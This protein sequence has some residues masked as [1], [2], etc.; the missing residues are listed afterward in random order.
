MSTPNDLQREVT[1]AA[2]DNFGASQLTLPNEGEG[3][4]NPRANRRRPACAVIATPNRVRVDAGTNASG[5]AIRARFDINGQSCRNDGREGPETRSRSVAPEF[6][7]VQRIWTTLARHAPVASLRSPC[8]RPVR[9]YGRQAT[10]PQPVAI[11]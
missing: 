8:H 4:L 6:P 3:P 1:I 5:Y 11:I 2:G 10:G 9:A 7:S